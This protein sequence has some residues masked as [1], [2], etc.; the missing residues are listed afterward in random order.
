MT[1]ENKEACLK[2]TNLLVYQQ[3]TGERQ[4]RLP[5]AD[6][7][8]PR[9]KPQICRPTPK[10]IRICTGK[11]MKKMCPP[12]YCD[13]S[14]K[15]PSKGLLNLL[16]FGLKVAAAAAAVYVTYDL[17]VWGSTDDTQ[18][19]Y[20][21]YCRI[22]RDPAK[23]KTEKWDPPS[24]EAERDFFKIPAFRPYGKC[25]YPPFDSERTGNNLQKHWNQA[26]EYV[27]CGLAGFP[28]N[29]IEKLRYKEKVVSKD[30]EVK[31]QQHMGGVD[32]VGMLVSSCRM[33]LKTHRWYTSIFSQILDMC[34]KNGWVLYERDLK[35]L[36]PEESP[37]TLKEFRNCIAES[38]LL[39]SKRRGDLCRIISTY[40]KR[41]SRTCSNHDPTVKYVMTMLVICL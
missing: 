16:R 32:L 2:K 28:Y 17:G 24:C 13:C 23:N 33:F 30:T 27:F 37:H 18:D 21:S 20:R 4:D 25:D 8:K 38:L 34:V 19:L 26:I 14:P 15:K 10:V 35:L 39:K 5:C 3:P 31:P 40:Q 36:Q 22:T 6:K 11:E 41:K 29:V 12:K 7:E 9:Y 1:G